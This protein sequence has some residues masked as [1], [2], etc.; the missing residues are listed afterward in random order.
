MQSQNTKIDSAARLGGVLRFF[1]TTE[2]TGD[3][4]LEYAV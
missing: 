3:L 2:V 1:P 4:F